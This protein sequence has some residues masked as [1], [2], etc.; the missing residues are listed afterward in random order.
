[1]K[2][3]VEASDEVLRKLKARLDREPQ[4]DEVSLR[5]DAD[6]DQMD[7]VELTLQGFDEPRTASEVADQ[8]GLPGDVART[9]LTRLEGQGVVGRLEDPELWRIR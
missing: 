7:L 8:A 2:L 9:A 5:G 6:D 3:E 1:M 4:V